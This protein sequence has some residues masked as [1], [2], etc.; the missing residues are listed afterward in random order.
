VQDS[1][2]GG[3]P[4]ARPSGFGAH[5]YSANLDQQPE[6]FMAGDDDSDED[7]GGKPEAADTKDSMG[8]DYDSDERNDEELVAVSGS[9]QSNELIDLGGGSE[10]AG[11]Q[12][13]AA[14]F[15][16]KLSGPQ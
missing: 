16:P 14:S 3:A 12:A 1:I 4:A 10:S 7:I 5:D 9:T 2:S 6:A 15:I 13:K 8:L 11:T